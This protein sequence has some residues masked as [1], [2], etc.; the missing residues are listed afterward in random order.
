MTQVITR[1]FAS[2]AQARSAK[3][4]LVHRRRLSVKIVDLYEDAKTVAD[5]LMAEDVNAD[6]ARAYADRLG[7]GGAVMLV[8][9][10]YQ[11]LG[12]A[13]ITR[14]VTAEMGAADMGGLTE[15][16][17]VKERSRPMLSILDDHPLILTRPRDPDSTNY[18]MADYPIPLI[19]RREPAPGTVMSTG[20]RIFS[21]PMPLTIR[22]KPY[23]D[24]IIPR[25]G[26]MAD[27][28]LPLT[29][30]RKPF[31]GSI[32]GRHARMAN[33]PLPLLSRRKPYTGSIISRHGR[34]ANWPIP[35]L[36]N[37]EMHTNSLMPG[38]PRMANFPIRLLSGRKPFTGSIFGRHARMA[39]F[40]IPLLSGRKPFTGS[41]I[42]KHGRMANFPW[43]LVVRNGGSNSYS[44]SEKLGW[45]MVIRR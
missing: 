16:V 30:R 22:L 10:G 29:N 8:R 44:L 31:T 24:M 20:P 40:P 2:P 5:K 4:E 34:K 37:G 41:V 12:V 42:P 27:K 1:Y 13:K 23:S 26:R 9:A 21:A 38:G 32:F 25:H 39:N 33:F 19:S 36:M 35:L 18:H 15:E 6:T 14:E 11:P 28:F 17:Y 43:P 45:K 7:S 3:H